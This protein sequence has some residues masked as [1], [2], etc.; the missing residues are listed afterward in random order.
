MWAVFVSNTYLRGGKF[1]E[2]EQMIL[3]AASDMGIE[4]RAMTNAELAFGIGAKGPLDQKYTDFILFWDKDVALARNLELAGHLVLNSSR[5]IAICDDK[6]MTHLTLAEWDIPSIDTIACPMS[7]SDYGDDP[8]FLNRAADALGFPMVVKDRFGSFGQQVRLV[9]DMESLARELSGP[10][11]PRILQRYVEC[12]A[13]DIRL[14]VVGAKVVAAVERR[15]P[16]S[17]FRSNVTIGGRMRRYNPTREEKCLAEMAA[18]VVGAEFCGVDIIRTPD[19]PAVCE[20][21]SNAHIKNLKDCTG[22]DVSY[23]IL[24][25]ACDIVTGDRYDL[26]DSI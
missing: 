22:K 26:L 1:S 18:I 13:T 3:D 2:P 5:C 11:V 23:D 20:V 10:Y 25:R 12:S 21:N 24:R 17:D 9:L 8:R 16:E 14:E 4:T 15:G 7:F 19:G 6:A